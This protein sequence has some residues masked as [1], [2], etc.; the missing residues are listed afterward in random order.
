MR[1]VA[2]SP[3]AAMTTAIHLP[4]VRATLGVGSQV[5]SGSLLSLQSNPVSDKRQR[6]PCAL[7]F[8]PYFFV[9]CVVV[10]VIAVWLRPYGLLVNIVF[11]FAA[12]Y[13]VIIIIGR[14]LLGRKN[15]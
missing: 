12:A 2:S 7:R 4:S 5:I 1:K 6:M 8:Y 11:A 3:T 13:L 10:T 14:R 9:A 15:L